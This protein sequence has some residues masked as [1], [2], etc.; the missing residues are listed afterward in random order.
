MHLLPEEITIAS[1]N[2][3]IDHNDKE[4]FKQRAKKEFGFY[5]TNHIYI[6][7]QGIYNDSDEIELDKENW[8][9]YQ[10][11]RNYLNDIVYI[12]NKQVLIT[13]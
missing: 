4:N 13:I 12:F 3:T 10:R 9:Y 5:T 2:Y 7:G 8:H 1:K 6:K 11:H